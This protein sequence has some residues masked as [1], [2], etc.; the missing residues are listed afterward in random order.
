MFS[1]CYQH[2]QGLGQPTEEQCEA[3]IISIRQNT[4]W[5]KCSRGGRHSPHHADSL[6]TTT[7]QP[8]WLPW[9]LSSKVSTCR[10][11]RHGFDPWRGTSPWRGNGYPLHFSCLENPMDREAWRAEVQSLQE[12]DT[13]EETEYTEPTKAAALPQE[14]SDT[15]QSISA[16]AMPWDEIHASQHQVNWS[17]EFLTQP[18]RK[19]D[20]W[21][22]NAECEPWPHWVFLFRQVF[23]LCFMWIAALS[24]H[25][26]CSAFI[27]PGPLTLYGYEADPKALILC[28]AFFFF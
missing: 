12:S 23:R 20:P 19:Q 11:R 6:E 24:H 3:C 2:T 21:W 25:R 10:C 8:T 17:R 22:Q 26:T 28:W 4:L 14:I 18:G 1:S 5:A 27:L 7:P 9:W 16:D 13:T 15:G